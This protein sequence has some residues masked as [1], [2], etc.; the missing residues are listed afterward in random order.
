[1]LFNE[2]IEK[3]GLE[4]ISSQTNISTTNLEYLINEDFEHLNRVK[5]LGFLLILEREYPDVDL[6]DLRAKIKG[7]YEEHELLEEQQVTMVPKDHTSGGGFSFFKLF[8]LLAIFG[9]GYYLYTQGKLDSMVQQIKENKNI[10][11][12]NKAL[13]NNASDEDAKKVLVKESE[14]NQSEEK[15]IQIE[16][17]VAPKEET[18]SLKEEPKKIAKKDTSKEETQ[19]VKKESQSAEVVVDK[20]SKEFIKNEAKN[21]IEEIVKEA[22]PETVTAP[23]STVTINPTRGMLWYG[24][25]NVETKKRREFMKQVSTPFELNNGQWLLVTGHGFLDIISENK[26]LEIADNKKHYFLIDSS[27][28]KEISKE[29]FREL[30]GHRGW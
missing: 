2:L 10:L 7:Y 19:S 12:D 27:D 5:A 20:V 4:S 30:N 13:E 28:I 16:T 18:I 9:G 6:S 15:S 25:I 17:P 29:E 24:F 21:T 23:I 8:I 1:M 22:K 26:T 11:D 14:S 3:E